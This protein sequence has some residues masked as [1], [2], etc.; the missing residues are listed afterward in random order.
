MTPSRAI[1]GNYIVR[2]NPGVLRGFSKMPFF[3]KGAFYG[4]FR[5]PALVLAWGA[6]IIPELGIL[7]NNVGQIAD[8][9]FEQDLPEIISIA[10]TIAFGIFSAHS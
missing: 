4:V 7:G 2:W 3:A 8:R 5:G 6:C 1:R 10:I 9:N